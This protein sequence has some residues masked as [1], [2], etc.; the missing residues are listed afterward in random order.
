M[1]RFDPSKQV[2]N[3]NSFFFN[4]GSVSHLK[5]GQGSAEKL[6]AS[7]LHK[8]HQSIQPRARKLGNEMH[9]F[10]SPSNLNIGLKDSIFAGGGSQSGSRNGERT[11]ALTNLTSPKGNLLQ[12]ERYLSKITSEK[13]NLTK[14]R[15]FNNSGFGLEKTVPFTQRR[16]E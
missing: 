7:A 14:H 2:L 12:Q 1:L 13:R 9:L 6:S 3:D 10:V 4:S 15:R 8:R 5:P 11:Q 16:I